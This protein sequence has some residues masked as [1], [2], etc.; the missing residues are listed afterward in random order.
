MD[1]LVHHPKHYN[2]HPSGVECIDLIEWLPCNLSNVVKYL[3]RKD[4]KHAQEIQDCE[5]ALWYLRRELRR[6]ADNP[7]L[8]DGT[9]FLPADVVDL[10]DLWRNQE[11]EGTRKVVIEACISGYNWDLMNAQTVLEDYIKEIEEK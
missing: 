5:K 10:V 2:A 6:T 7:Q 9:Y 1:P 4:D 3:W 11:P 8:V